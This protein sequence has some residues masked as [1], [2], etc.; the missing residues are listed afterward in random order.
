MSNSVMLVL[1]G[2]EIVSI[3]YMVCGKISYGRNGDSYRL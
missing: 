1:I 3:V 2:S